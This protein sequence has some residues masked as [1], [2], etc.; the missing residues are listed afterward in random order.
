MH[1]YVSYP[2]NPWHNSYCL[3]QIANAE[4]MV[5][6]LDKGLS[7]S[8]WKYFNNVFRWELSGAKPSG[9]KRTVIYFQVRVA[10]NMNERQQMEGEGHET[11]CGRG[12]GIGTV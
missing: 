9:G 7:S 2:S 4:V 11:G 5:S 12:L 3:N 1:V 6:L 8:W 10:C